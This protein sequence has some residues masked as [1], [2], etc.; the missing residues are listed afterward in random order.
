[1]MCLHTLSIPID[2]GI[3]LHH[4]NLHYNFKKALTK[5]MCNVKM[6]PYTLDS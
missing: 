1:M 6:F 5:T 4:D 3:I 2:I